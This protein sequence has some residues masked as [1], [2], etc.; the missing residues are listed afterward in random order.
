MIEA[1]KRTNSGLV[2]NT[3]ALPR[4]ASSSI[5]WRTFGNEGLQSGR[6]HSQLAVIPF[7]DNRFGKS[8]FPFGRQGY[9]G[10]IPNSLALALDS[11]RAKRVRTC[12]VIVIRLW[13]EATASE[14]PS[15]IV[16]KSRM[17]TRSCSKFCKMR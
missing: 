16:G 14:M 10:M 17:E 7:A 3:A 5:T 12:S 6:R 11:R 9:Q 15:K 2:S 1:D 13:V 8:V 4:T